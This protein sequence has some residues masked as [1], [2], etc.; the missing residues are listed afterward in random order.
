[1][2]LLGLQ[3]RSPD[4]R[5]SSLT[6]SLPMLRAVK[7]DNE[8]ARLAAAGAAADATYGE[9]VKVRF[10]GRRETDVAGRPGRPAAAASG[11]S[12]STSPSSARGPTAPTRTTRP[13]SG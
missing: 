2:H 5:Y 1:M 7:D 3:R 10:A 11:T 12:R 9:I 4:S 13:V 8:L 6:Q